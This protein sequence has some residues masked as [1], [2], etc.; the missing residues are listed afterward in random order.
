MNIFKIESHLDMAAFDIM[1][2]KQVFS[3][4]YKTFCA[5]TVHNK[6]TKRR[7]AAKMARASR[8]RNA[9]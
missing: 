9:K 6:I 8:K 4:K 7:K 3:S 5:K 1:P 2:G